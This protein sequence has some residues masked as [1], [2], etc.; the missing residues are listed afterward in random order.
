M[1]KT[2][3]QQVVS[4]AIDRVNEVLPEENLLSK[5]RHTKLMGEGGVL[6]SMGFVNFI[7]A[8]EEALAA[9]TGFNINIVEELNAAGNKG[10]GATTLEELTDFLLALV[11]S[12]LAG[13]Q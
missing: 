7:V 1:D 3:M 6:D 9:A 13:T 8:L 2:E 4:T 10:S 12:K 5:D 11:K